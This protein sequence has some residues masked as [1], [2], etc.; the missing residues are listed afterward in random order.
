[1]EGGIPGA[2]ARARVSVKIVV[3]GVVIRVFLFFLFAFRGIALFAL[4]LVLRDS[5]GRCTPVLGEVN[6]LKGILEI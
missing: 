4:F 3:N 2:R 6:G 5:S 1:M